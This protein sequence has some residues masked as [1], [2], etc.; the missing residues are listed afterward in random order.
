MRHR[1]GIHEKNIE[2]INLADRVDVAKASSFGSFL[3]ALQS[4]IANTSFI[5]INLDVH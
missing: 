4:V 2:D 5:Q 3:M 1:N